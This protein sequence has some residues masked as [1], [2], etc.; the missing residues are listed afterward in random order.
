V[1][2]KSEVLASSEWLPHYY[3][4][5][6]QRVQFVRLERDKIRELTFLADY[7]PSGG[8]DSCWLTAEE[9][10][11]ESVRPGTLH[12]VFHTAFARSTLLT[13]ALDMPGFSIGLSEP[14]ILNELAIGGPKARELLKPILRLLARPFADGE[15]VVV[16]PSNTANG[17]IEEMLSYNEQSRALLL[18]GTLESF[19]RSVNKKGM[20]GRRWV[21]RLFTHIM[22]FAPL[23]FGMSQSEQFEATDLQYAGLTWLLQQRQFAMLLSSNAGARMRSLDSD[24][25][26]SEREQSLSKLSTFFEIDAPPEQIRA[27]VEGP[28]F[29]THAKLGGDY[30]SRIEIEEQG[31]ES[32]VVEEEIALVAQWVRQVAQMAGIDWPLARPLL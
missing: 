10:N 26:N 2:Q 13:R 15:A 24:H 8:Q 5:Q 11:N 3:D 1:P 29:N 6:G 23:D 21:R 16:K 30:K 18:T 4:A 14:K 28:V 17:L 12:F 9:I 27:I 20:M 22:Q 32:S 19:L 7:Q 31:A 25:F